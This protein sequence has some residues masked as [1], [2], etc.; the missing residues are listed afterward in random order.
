MEE[1]SLGDRAIGEVASTQAVFNSIKNAINNFTIEVTVP[2]GDKKDKL[3]TYR[4][5]PKTKGFKIGDETVDVDTYLRIYLQ[6]AADNA[7]FLLLS[8][9][10]YSVDALRKSLFDIYELTPDF[11]ERKVGRRF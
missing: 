6:D 3:V 10:N 9:W 11:K 8:D 4:I 1:M 5:K 2:F 7:K